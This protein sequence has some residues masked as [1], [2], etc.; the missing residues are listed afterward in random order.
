MLWYR[1]LRDHT[2]SGR[3][4]NLFKLLLRHLRA[5]PFGRE[6]LSRREPGDRN[7]SVQKTD[8]RRANLAWMMGLH[9]GHVDIGNGGGDE[10][11]SSIDLDS[12]K[13]NS[14]F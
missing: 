1:G 6:V 9:F 5:T 11:N 3:G 4:I 12:Q 8:D 7:A 14:Q 10:R 13:E 2:I